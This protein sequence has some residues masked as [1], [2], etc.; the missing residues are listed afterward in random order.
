MIKPKIQGN[1]IK[2]NTKAKKIIKK[3]NL[4]HKIKQKIKEKLNRQTGCC[5]LLVSEVHYCMNSVTSL[6]F[7]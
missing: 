1:K 5:E 2:I 3:Q 6:K 4:K 7:G